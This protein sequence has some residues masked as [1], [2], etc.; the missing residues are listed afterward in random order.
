MV[1]QSRGTDAPLRPAARFAAAKE[2]AH[3]SSRKQKTVQEARELTTPMSMTMLRLESVANGYGSLSSD[4]QTKD[5]MRMNLAGLQ[6]QG[7]HRS[8]F[9]GR[10][11]S[12]EECEGVPYGQD[13]QYTE[14]A[15]LLKKSGILSFLSLLATSELWEEIEIGDGFWRDLE[16]WVDSFESRNCVKLNEPFLG[17]AAI[18]GTDASGW[19]TGQVA[20][21]DGGCDECVLRF[22]R[23]E[24]RRSINWRELLGVLRIIDIFG[25]LS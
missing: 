16:W 21:I 22:G 8:L 14:W 20:W 10:V 12:E 3:G 4:K 11:V 19:G 1:C 5:E 24:Q 6:I 17:E 15:R 25:E 18:T 9:K 2:K 7:L 13:C 23:A